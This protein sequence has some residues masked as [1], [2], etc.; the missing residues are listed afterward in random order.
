MALHR[1]YINGEWLEGKGVRENINP[2]D[3]TDIVGKYAQADKAQTEA[4]VKAAVDSAVAPVLAE[5]K[6]LQA[7]VNAGPRA[8]SKDDQSV[9]VGEKA[10]T[11]QA[12]LKSG[13]END[14]LFAQLG[15]TVPTK[16]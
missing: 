2:S 11:A 6:A 4:A 13:G 7:L 12:Q 1:N 9:V 16:G 5:L 15:M 3:I 8:A 14:P 10:D